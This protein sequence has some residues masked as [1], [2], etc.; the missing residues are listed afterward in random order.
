MSLL[1]DM[2]ALLRWARAVDEE[3]LKH[4]QN[5]MGS[6]WRERV[7]DVLKQAAEL[8]A[9]PKSPALEVMETGK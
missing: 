3:M 2:L 4:E 1:D 7:D 9:P 5:I 6:L 8:A